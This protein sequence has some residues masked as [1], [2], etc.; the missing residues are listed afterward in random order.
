[1]ITLVFIKYYTFLDVFSFSLVIIIFFL[2]G[3]PNEGLAYDVTTDPIEGLA[4]VEVTTDPMEG[5]P[6]DFLVLTTTDFLVSSLFI[7]GDL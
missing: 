1:M 2:F 6:T 5:L 4:A 3:V 7:L